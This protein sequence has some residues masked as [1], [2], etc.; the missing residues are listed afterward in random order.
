M[1]ASHSREIAIGELARRAQ[2]GWARTQ[3]TVD[4]C[5]EIGFRYI[6]LVGIELWTK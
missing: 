4:I 5:C 6:S 2:I 1:R 3:E